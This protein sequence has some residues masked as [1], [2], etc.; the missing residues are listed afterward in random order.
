MP[1][2]GD[3]PARSRRR[4]R[5]ALQGWLLA[6]TLTLFL[7]QGI[8]RPGRGQEV[9]VTALAGLTLVVAFRAARARPALITAVTA[10]AVATVVT[11]LLTGDEGAVQ[12]MNAA[13]TALGP[14]AIAISIV[15]GVRLDGRIRVSAVSGVLALYLLIGMCFSFVYGALDRLGDQPFFTGGDSATVSHCLYFSF[16]T[17]TTVGYGD[18]TAA[19]DTGHTLSALEALIGQIY[20]VTIVALIV[21]NLG[22]PTSRAR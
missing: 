1:P 7:V 15:R 13:V 19:T 2:D 9:V 3:E 6:L 18:F 22:R 20:L 5:V 11:S 17:M 10:L 16:I 4:E 8:S 14:P 21:G 12:V